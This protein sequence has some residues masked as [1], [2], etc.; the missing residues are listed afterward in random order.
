MCALC[1]SYNQKFNNLAQE[2]HRNVHSCAIH[3]HKFYILYWARRIYNLVR[4]DLTLELGNIV[5]LSFIMIL[6]KVP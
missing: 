1:D 4:S 2:D 5:I 3:M 6:I